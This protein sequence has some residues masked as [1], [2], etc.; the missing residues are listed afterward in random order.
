MEQHL[1]S[2]PPG[3][4][5]PS[6]SLLKADL[7]IT[8]PRL[9]V[10]YFQAPP[11]TWPLRWAATSTAQQPTALFA[12]PKDQS[13]NADA[14]ESDPE[15]ESAEEQSQLPNVNDRPGAEEGSPSAARGDDGTINPP[16]P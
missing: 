16:F 10:N 11:Q 6:L 9:L 5:F 14:D 4:G 8:L 3:P 1:I 13:E 7:A 12:A 15:L 2:L